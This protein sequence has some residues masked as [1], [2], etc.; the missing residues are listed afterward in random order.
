[1][2]RREES[3]AFSPAGSRWRRRSLLGA[4][5]LL[6]L[7]SAPGA[8]PEEFVRDPEGARIEMKGFISDLETFRLNSEDDDPDAPQTELPRIDPS[9]TEE[10]PA[11]EA[12]P[13]AEKPPQPKNS[14][15]LTR[16][17]SSGTESG[18]AAAKGQPSQASP[19]KASFPPVQVSSGKKSETKKDASER[20]TEVKARETESAKGDKSTASAGP[21]KSPEKTAEKTAKSVARTSEEKPSA[22]SSA[23]AAAPRPDTSRA[24]SRGDLTVN[25]GNGRVAAVRPSGR[26]PVSA[27]PPEGRVSRGSTWVEGTVTGILPRPDGRL[28]V[29][30][31]TRS[32]E[33]VQ[34]VVS[35]RYAGQSIQTGQYVRLQ[36][37]RIGGSDHHPVVQIAE[38][39][40]RIEESAMPYRRTRETASAPAPAAP[41]VFAPE[42]AFLPEP[43][44][45]FLA[46]APVVGPTVIGGPVPGGAFL[47]PPVIGGPVVAPPPVW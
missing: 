22:S 25:L 36:G 24:L 12:K 23:R 21:A 3:V 5:S 33:T 30:V 9:N 34:V 16:R 7:A 15:Q 44:S 40:D 28:H 20:R 31:A 46:P 2:N 39:E 45:P 18:K 13:A 17:A 29:L 8:E 35:G 41:P 42:P 19:S 32:R 4:L 1:M 47:G 38:E 43:V 11:S 6:A 37:E 26:E 14:D 10:K 27:R